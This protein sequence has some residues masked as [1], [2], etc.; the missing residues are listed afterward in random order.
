ME[1][2]TALKEIRSISA[3]T[4]AE[5][6]PTT[7]SSWVNLANEGGLHLGNARAIFGEPSLGDGD[8]TP[9]TIQIWG[10]EGDVI[11]PL[12]Q[13]TMDDDSD[14][15]DPVELGTCPPSWS[16]YATVAEDVTG[17]SPEVSVDVYVQR[18]TDDA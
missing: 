16:F 17:T 14:L 7:S 4:S 11:F 18:Y 6:A 8:N 9:V 2:A 12:K 3:V 5:S 13:V 15:I 10:R 1:Q